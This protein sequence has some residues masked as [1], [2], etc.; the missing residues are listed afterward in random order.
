MELAETTT[1]IKQND[2]ELIYSNPFFAKTKEELEQLRYDKDNY[3]YAPVSSLPSTNTIIPARIYHALSSIMGEVLSD[4]VDF[5]EYI[6]SRLKYDFNDKLELAK[7]FSGEQVDALTLIIYSIENKKSLE[8]SFILS[9][10]TGIGKGRVIAGVIR[11]AYQNGKVPIFVTYTPKLYSD[12]IRDINDIGGIKNTKDEIDRLGYPFVTNS[13]LKTK[14]TEADVYWENRKGENILISSTYTSKKL[15]KKLKSAKKNILPKDEKGRKYDMI[16]SVYSQIQSKSKYSV[17]KQEFL[18]KYIEN[19]ILILDESHKA[20]G[21][22]STTGQVFTH[23]VKS[24]YGVLF[25]SATFSKTHKNL[26]IYLQ[27]SS[28]KNIERYIDNSLEMLVGKGGNVISEYITSIFVSKGEMIRRERTFANTTVEYL[29]DKNNEE[30]QKSLFDNILDK[31]RKIISVYYGDEIKNAIW[32][33]AISDIRK[34]L[35]ANEDT[36][37]ISHKSFIKDIHDINDLQEKIDEHRGK[38][39]L[40]E[41]ES[42]LKSRLFKAINSMLYSVKSQSIV[43]YT[44]D[45]MFNDHPYNIPKRVKKNKNRLGIE[46][47]KGNGKHKPIIAIDSTLE[48]ALDKLKKAGVSILENND[49]SYY[50]ISLIEEG[51]TVEY[52]SAIIGDWL[53]DEYKSDRKKIKYDNAGKYSINTRSYLGEL[54]NDFSEVSELISLVSEKTNIPLSPIDYL[55]EKLTE[56]NI[57]VNE[58]TGRTLMLK[59]LDDGKY[60]IMANKLND[61]KYR[62]DKI[63]SFN[64]NPNNVL[65]INSAGSTGISLHSSANYKDTNPR[66]MLFMEID[67]K[68]DV[69]VQKRGRIYRTGQLNFPTYLYVVSSIPAELR[70]LVVFKKK[71]AVLDSNASANQTQSKE[72][73]LMQD[74]NGNEIEDIINKYGDRVS[75]SYLNLPENQWLVSYLKSLSLWGKVED[76]EISKLLRYV[77]LLDCDTQRRI[78]DDLNIIYKEYVDKLKQSNQYDLE[79]KYEQYLASVKNIVEKTKIKDFDSLYEGDY[80]IKNDTKILMLEEVKSKEESLMNGKKK[81][82]FMNDF[83]S[84][85]S[86]SVKEQKDDEIQRNEEKYEKEIEKTSEKLKTIEDDREKD[87]TPEE[88]KKREGRIK[89]LK[90]KIEKLKNEKANNNAQIIRRWDAEKQYKLDIFNTLK[91]DKSVKYYDGEGSTN[92]SLGRFVGYKIVSNERKYLFGDGNIEFHFAMLHGTVPYSKLKLSS[93][94]DAIND[95]VHESKNMLPYEEQSITE[96]NVNKA[97]KRN[98]ARIFT[99]NLSIGLSEAIKLINNDKNKEDGWLA[100]KFVVFNYNMKPEK[101][102]AGIRMIPRDKIK[103]LSENNVFTRASFPKEVL[104]LKSMYLFN[105]DE[106]DVV[107]R[108]YTIR[109]PYTI[110]GLTIGCPLKITNDISSNYIERNFMYDND[111]KIIGVALPYNI[112]FKIKLGTIARGKYYLSP[113]SLSRARETLSKKNREDKV[114]NDKELESFLLKA[115][116]HR[117]YE[118]AH[119]WIRWVGNSRESKG[120]V[121]KFDFQARATIMFTKHYEKQ[122]YYRGKEYSVASMEIKYDDAIYELF[123]IMEKYNMYASINIKNPKNQ[124]NIPDTFKEVGGD[125]GVYDIDTDGS[126][127]YSIRDFG[128]YEGD[129]N[130][131]AIK[132]IDNNNIPKGY[133]QKITLVSYL[134]PTVMFKYGLVPDYFENNTPSEVLSKIIPLSVRDSLQDDSQEKAFRKALSEAIKGGSS[135]F[136]IS[137]I[138]SRYLRYSLDFIVGRTDNYNEER[139]DK[140]TKQ[141]SILKEYYL[142]KDIVYEEKQAE[143]IEENNEFLGK[144]Y[145]NVNAKNVREYLLEILRQI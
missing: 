73:G 120:I 122:D 3:V 32:Q 144:T 127:Y 121:L 15:Y 48:S 101:Y 37:I 38:I 134:K 100:Y 74:R 50:L 52:E 16:F 47:I 106:N 124:F 95:I 86:L 6:M 60:E 40:R 131:E 1:D 81:D 31:T 115:E 35:G 109:R 18:E 141:L 65:I 69:Q 71:L 34:E 25:S 23:L 36:E 62:A 13:G 39:L 24:A 76:L 79:T 133:Y 129:F 89:N 111:D 128:R 123:D 119:S 8:K 102:T 107:F 11:Y 54:R 136:M 2:N 14:E 130:R 68:I 22:K 4:V 92:Y 140:M 33:Y 49:Y 143:E 126:I 45:Y 116:H 137:T 53:I 117:Y 5:D 9:D 139:G 56:K 46:I 85:F 113:M 80:Y 103:Q 57:I 12:M 66:V 114:L 41:K 87:K 19:S 135:E 58:I 83:I 104:L 67:L 105:T 72:L 7:Y 75:Q 97:Q 94:K 112:E 88:K 17:A 138:L 27:R 96:W 29:Y 84:E 91:P 59:K 64:N 108:V 93:S 132:S 51:S 77:Q 63:K 118:F 28:I 26:N 21:G 90:E 82:K 10:M 61:K 70:Q 99:G 145:K 20:S 43:D 110:Y 30:S 44:I 98:I 78:Y 125:E 42:K 142:D 55:I